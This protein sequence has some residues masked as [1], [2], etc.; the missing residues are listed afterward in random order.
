[1]HSWRRQ[2]VSKRM[3]RRWGMSGGGR[4]AQKNQKSRKALQDI[5]HSKSQKSSKENGGVRPGLATGLGW[6]RHSLPLIGAEQRWAHGRVDW[7]GRKTLR[8]QN[9]VVA[10]G[11]SQFSFPCRCSPMLFLGFQ[12]HRWGFGRIRMR[13]RQHYH[14]FG[15]IGS[16]WMRW[17]R[18]V[19][20]M[21][22]CQRIIQISNVLNA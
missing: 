10:C 20:T 21:G 16:A 14:R 4:H 18:E 7:A 15:S 1:M 3:S 11:Y 2:V 12:N 6:I 22:L 17:F 13:S 9:L 19:W 5:E 8:P